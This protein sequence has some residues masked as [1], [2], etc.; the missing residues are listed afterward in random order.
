M[1]KILDK[2]PADWGMTFWVAVGFIMIILFFLKLWHII[3]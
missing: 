2:L 3:K 1:R